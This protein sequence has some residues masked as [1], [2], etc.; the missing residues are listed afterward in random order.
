MRN[1]N[2]NLIINQACIYKPRFV[3][4]PAFPMFLRPRPCHHH[5]HHHHHYWWCISSASAEATIDINRCAD[6]TG[7]L[8]VKTSL[9]PKAVF[10]GGLWSLSLAVSNSYTWVVVEETK[11]KTS[12]KLCSIN[13]FL[14]D[15]LPLFGSF[16]LP[17]DLGNLDERKAIYF[18]RSLS[19]THK[20]GPRYINFTIWHQII[21][22][23]SLSTQLNS[24]VD[25][26]HFLFHHKI[27]DSQMWRLLNNFRCIKVCSSS[28]T[29]QL[30]N[31]MAIP[32][33]DLF[34]AI[35]WKIGTESFWIFFCF[36]HCSS[37]HILH[38]VIHL[39]HI[40]NIT[41]RFQ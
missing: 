40:K 29:A 27:I 26:S 18:S 12:C 7:W 35:T 11:K 28:C 34:I 15:F 32:L 23:I 10:R 36:L 24:T 39:W 2:L 3:L 13:H 9:S 4:F 22:K 6:Q 19:R 17:L 41:F 14:Y 37:P 21:R 30:L 8:C 31:L 38:S 25:L 1:Y 20:Q 16:S 33:Y 5:Y